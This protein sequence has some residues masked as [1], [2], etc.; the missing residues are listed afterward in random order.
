MHHS[1]IDKH[2]TKLSTLRNVETALCNHHKALDTHASKISAMQGRKLPTQSGMALREGYAKTV[3]EP[4]TMNVQAMRDAAR[5]N[6]DA[7]RKAIA[8]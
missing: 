6:D 1:A 2:T 4:T 7:M 8:R 5:R 3:S